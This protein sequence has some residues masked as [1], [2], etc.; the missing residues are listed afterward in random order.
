MLFCVFGENSEVIYIFVAHF[1]LKTFSL[2]GGFVF[3]A[4]GGEEHRSLVQKGQSGRW[5]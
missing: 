2:G 1:F 4:D 5:T 3:V